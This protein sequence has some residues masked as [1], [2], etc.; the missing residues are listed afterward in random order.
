MAAL[1]AE[2]HADQLRLKPLF[3]NL[4]YTIDMPAAEPPGAERHGWRIIA[5]RRRPD[6]TGDYA[7]DP[8][9]GFT[10]DSLQAT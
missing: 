2:E 10:K 6:P 1:C 8:G 9:D 3:F 5:T 7:Q 4:A